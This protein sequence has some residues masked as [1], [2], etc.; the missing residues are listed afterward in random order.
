M[1][2]TSLTIIVVLGLC[3]SAFFVPT[4]AEKIDLHYPASWP[5]PHYDF[6]SNP[7]STKKVALG[8]NLFYD[9]ILSKDN[10]ISCASCHLS[11]TAFTHVDHALSHGIGDSIG[12]RNSMTLVNMA[13]GKHFMWDGAIN[14]LEVQALAPISHEDEMGDNITSVIEKLQKSK[15]YPPLFAQA[16][17]DSVI[18]SQNMLK[19]ITQFELTFVSSYAKYDKVMRNEA[20][21]TEQEARG[22]QFFKAKCATCHSEPL[23][24]NGEFENIGLP[25]DPEL[26]DFG[27]YRITNRPNDSLK[28]KVPSL[29]NIEFSQ[30][31]MHDGRFTSLHQVLNH[32]TEHVHFSKTVSKDIGRGIA[33]TEDD[34]VDVISFLLTLTDKDF[35]FNQDLSYP[36]K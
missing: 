1:K 17:G 32:Y 33:L 3:T 9:P 24:T 16:F 13:W 11:Y 30:P 15:K 14:N 25:V 34:R 5:K 28:F 26:N 22:Y 36:K 7:L 29:R 2:K 4:E 31:Y 21:F 8:R 35:L 12:S 23:F 6:D 20:E 27:R 19:A 10:M 18:T